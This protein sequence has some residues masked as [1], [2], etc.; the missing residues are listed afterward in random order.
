MSDKFI[1][2]RGARQHNLAGIDV[3]IPRE[4]LVVITGLSGSGKSSLAF[5]TV[6]AEGRRKYVESLSVHARQFLEQL[7]KPDVDTIEGLPPTLAIEQHTTAAG[8]R[9]TVGTITEIH[10]FLRLL[11]A[12]VGTPHCP[13]CGRRIGKTTAVQIVDEV[14]RLPEG[15]KVVV[16][17][18]MV[19]GEKGEHP[20]VLRRI[21]REGFVRVRINGEMHDVRNPP[22]PDKRRKF[23]IEAVV[24]RL[25]VKPDVRSRLADSVEL[26]LKTADG[27]VLVSREAAPDRW[28]ETLF[29]ERFAC[30]DCGGGFEE[31]SPRLF[32]FNS[33]HGMCPECG[34]LG[35]LAEFDPDLVVP[36]HTVS[37]NRGA[38]RPWRAVSRKDSALYAQA[39]DDFAARFGADLNLPFAELSAAVR[40][41]LLHG[42]TDAAGKPFEGVLPNLK[43]RYRESAGDALKARLQPFLSEQSCPACKGARLRPEAL[44]VRVMTAETPAAEGKATASKAKSPKPPPLP[45]LGLHDLTRLTIE[46]AHDLFGRLELDAEQRAV[47]EPILAE[48]RRRLGFLID[49]GV[50][51]LSLDRAG[52]T[53]SGGESQRIRLA[54]QVGSGL[55]GVCYVLDEPTIGLHQ[56]DNRR[57]IDTLRKMADMGNTVL[58]VEHDE[59]TIRA[60][61][62]V[63][64]I[65][66]GAGASG[67]R[68]VAQGTVAE[69][70][71]DP[72][73][74][75][76][77]Y[78][79]GRKA[80]AVPATRRPLRPDYEIRVLG[81]RENNLRNVDVSFPLGVLCCVT[82]VSGSGKSTLVNEILLRGLKRRLTGSR[83]R[84][85]AH[86]RIT[87]SGN[88]ARVV[89]IDQTPIGRSPRSNPATYAGVF[90]EIRKVFAKTKEAKLRGYD[91]SR[92]SFNVKGG[93]CEACQGQGTKRINM[94]FLPDVFVECRECRG[95]RYNRETLEIRYR[96]RDISEVLDLRIEEAAAL[97]DGFPQIRGVL[98][99]LR[100]VGVGYL[101]LGQS[102]AMLSGGEAQRIK[103]GSELGR[104]SGVGS[105]HALYVLDEP[106][107]GLHFAD[108]ARLMS[109]LNRLVDAGNS[110]IVI[111]HNLDVIK[112]ADWVIDLGP[113]GGSGGGSVV[114]Q[115]TPEQIAAEERSHT[116]RFLRGKLTAVAD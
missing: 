40:A 31:L 62:H 44:A 65:G 39:L 94:D 116:G 74:P 53:L 16:M 19:R 77:E 49:V 89:E 10:D 8:P 93:R 67:G 104:A 106:T 109:V 83:E 45:G 56:R 110:V 2:I 103:L 52:P 113:E 79:S 114:A 84:A 111:E 76:G 92:F 108:I 13:D 112:C 20:D 15:T 22:K 55:V 70:A 98:T 21:Q 54:G 80:I 81:A 12:R 42:G 23:T 115:G 97:F 107:T 33:P 86:D 47:A 46:A 90:D 38:I 6:Y 50:G 75:T 78:L 66:P 27:L 35:L 18:P 11:F 88:V 24:D 51:Y 95:R 58:V 43:R 4:K 68:V 34:G 64:D 71:A 29:S 7:Q 82:G 61:D 102:A 59:D 37:L 73:S 100:D 3:D 99:A 101:S 57:L 72:D 87:G 85:G 36:D 96:G 105:G 17:A 14:M 91:A 41:A 63:F 60:A 26:A 25:I 9:T 30:P 69:L 28:E 32:S 5:D 48:V 1:R